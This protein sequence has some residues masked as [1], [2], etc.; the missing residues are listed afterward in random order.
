VTVDIFTDNDVILKLARYELLSECVDLFTQH[1]YVF[2]YLDA[3]PFVAGV[4]AP[5]RAKKMGLVPAQVQSIEYFISQ[6]SLVTISDE[7][8]LNVIAQLRT[9]H[10]DGGELILTFGAQ[11]NKPSNLF[12]GDKRA[13]EAVNRMQCAGVLAL[14]GCHV[15][16]LE[17]AI[18]LLMI[19]GNKE[20]VIARIQAHPLV[21]KAID[22]CFRNTGSVDNA[23][24][25]YI[26]SIRSQCSSLSFGLTQNV[27]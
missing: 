6:S 4:N 9:P 24:N 19:C 7:Q 26:K 27:C 16:V 14:G 2:R 8:A 21:D 23:L 22:I 25:S 5:S 11:E 15:L 3:L 1:N 12:T 10:L 18:R 17:E 20:Q 13:L